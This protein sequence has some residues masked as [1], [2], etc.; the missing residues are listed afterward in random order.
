MKLLEMCNL[1]TQ[2][3]TEQIDGFILV[4]EEERVVAVGGL[5]V[6]GKEALLRSVAVVPDRRSAGLGKAICSELELRAA[7]AGVER[8]FLLT[9]DAVPYFLGL[10]FELVQR[11]ETPP[12]IQ[13]TKQFGSLCPSTA[14]VMNIR[15]RI[16]GS[17]NNSY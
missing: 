15:V 13:A 1:P 12:V 16:S 5:E 17:E 9:E 6:Y 4:E 3:C 11:E 2:D 14:K 7:G 8:I 10:G